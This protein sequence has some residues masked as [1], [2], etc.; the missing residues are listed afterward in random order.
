MLA[1]RGDKLSGLAVVRVRLACGRIAGVAA[2]VSEVY[3]FG[4]PEGPHR[5]PWGAAYHREAVH[6]YAESLPWSYQRD[7]ARLFRD[8]EEAMARQSIASDLAEDWVIIDGYMREAAGSI[9]DWLASDES[10]SRRSRPAPTP[11][12]DEVP[13][14][15][16][17]D[18]LA[19]LTTSEGIRRL[20]RAALRVQQHFDAMSSQSLDGS[21]RLMLK[22]LVSGVP[23]VDVAS[24]M[25][26]SERSM[27]RALSKLWVKLGVSGR[28][29]GLHKATLE[30]LID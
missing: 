18:A 14:V 29:A 26:Y 25:G 30:G 21:E 27:Y 9:E 15:I 6:V 12:S 17:F 2:A 4:V 22:R 23:I 24:E 7:M 13:R 28:T 20:G 10:A 3:G 8:G 11:E 16:H 5:E 1:C 19:R